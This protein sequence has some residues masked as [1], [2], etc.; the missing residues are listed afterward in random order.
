MRT[1]IKQRKYD[2]KFEL[3]GLMNDPTF[4]EPITEKNSQYISQRWVTIGVFNN[5]EEA[6]KARYQK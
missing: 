6:T 5:E 3:I 1:E 4:E 2:G